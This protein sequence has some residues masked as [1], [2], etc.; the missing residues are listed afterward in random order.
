[1]GRLIVRPARAEDAPA[2]AEIYAYHV[3]NGAGTF[4]EAA[5]SPDAIAARLAAVRAQGLPWVVAEA[6]GAVRAFAYASPFRLRAAYR[7]LA[8]DSVYVAPDAQRKGLGRA[9]LSAVIEACEGL[10]LRQLVALIGDSDNAGSRGLHRALGFQ[11][12]GVL[13]AA[14]FKHG[15]WVDVVLMT[16]ALNG[17]GETPPDAAGLDL[18]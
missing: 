12:A 3:L 15:R 11:P 7:Y 13:P 18:N 5:P 6:E 9:A 1:M 14:G 2:L 4:E 16:R 17:G 10:G 8:E